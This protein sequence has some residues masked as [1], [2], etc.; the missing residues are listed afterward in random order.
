MTFVWDE[1]KRLSN[2]QKHGLDFADADAIFSFFVL[3]KLDDREDYGEDRWIVIG[4]LEGRTVV[5]VYAE[6]VSGPNRLI[7]LRKA[8]SHERAEYQ[9]ALRDRLGEG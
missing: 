9:Q 7:S 2:L 3:R 4:L 5:L 6:G 8:T 1:T